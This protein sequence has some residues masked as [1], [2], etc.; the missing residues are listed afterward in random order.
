M[1]IAVSLLDAAG[2]A[3]LRAGLLDRY[4]FARSLL[5][6]PNESSLRAIPDITCLVGVGRHF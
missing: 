3:L 2:L 4:S 1:I 6:V 5:D